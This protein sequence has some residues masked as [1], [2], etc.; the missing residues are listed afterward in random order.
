MEI[1][2]FHEMMEAL[3]MAEEGPEPVELNS[4][5]FFVKALSYFEGEAIGKLSSDE[6][7]P[8]TPVK[9]SNSRTEI[10][11]VKTAIMRESEHCDVSQLLEELTSNRE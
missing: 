3:E 8:S 9:S 10:N 2:E 11:A 5:E 1:L 7:S 6:Q 4:F